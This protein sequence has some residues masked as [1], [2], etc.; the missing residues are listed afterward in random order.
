M[1]LLCIYVKIA[2]IVCRSIVSWVLGHLWGSTFYLY[3]LFQA[4]QNLLGLDQ[5]LNVSFAGDGLD[6]LNLQEDSPM[7]HPFVGL[8]II[9]M[10]AIDIKQKLFPLL[11]HH[12][13]N[14]PDRLSL[15]KQ[16]LIVL[17]CQH[18]S[19]K[20]ELVLE[21]EQFAHDSGY[22]MEVLAFD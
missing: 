18:A 16:W 22:D 13:L 14:S 1:L 21:V 20:N 2:V 10:L 15:R 19:L 8:K 3:Q 6:V 11:R 9:K 5:D 12:I 7:V 4:A 17:E